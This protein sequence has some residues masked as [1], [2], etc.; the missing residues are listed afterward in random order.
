MSRVVEKLADVELVVVG[1][2]HRC[3]VAHADLQDKRKF[4][5]GCDL[6]EF[7]AIGDAGNRLDGCDVVHAIEAVLVEAGLGVS[8]EVKFGLGCGCSIPP[9][10]HVGVEVLAALTKL[11][12]IG[13]DTF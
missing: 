3:E 7:G 1:P 9:S 5:L 12:R 11:A 2:W 4:D 6:E 8:F 10:A 13:V